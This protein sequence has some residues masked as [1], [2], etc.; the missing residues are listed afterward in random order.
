MQNWDYP[1]DILIKIRKPSR[2]IGEEPFFPKKDWDSTELKVCLGYPDLYEVGRSHLGI[3]ILSY[4]INASRDYLC[5]FVFAVAPDFET[6]LKKQNIPLLSLNYRKPIKEFDILG[7]SYAYELTATGIL[8][9][10]DLGK[11][12]LKTEDRK[13]TDPVVIGG[14]PSCGN[15]EPVADFFDAIVIGDGEEVIFEILELI[16]QWKNSGEKRDALWKELAKIEGVYVPVLKNK[17]KKRILKDLNKS[18]L[19]WIFGIP[20]IEL[21]HD[22]IP[23][24]ISRGCTRGCRFCEAGFYYRP[25]REK[26]VSYILEQLWKNFNETGYREASLMSLSTGDFTSLK[27]LIRSLRESFYADYKL[28]LIHISEPTRPY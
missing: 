23:L 2:Y 28:S 6:E 4:L 8:N 13:R 24:E 20:V 26:T 14:G 16:K 12:P 18:E 7:I 22:R 15:P 10:L 25:V 9:I 17:V 3:N 5:D 21:A 11:V 19:C 1:F 27:T